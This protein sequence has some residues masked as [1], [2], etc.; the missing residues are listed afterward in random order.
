MAKR[1]LNVNNDHPYRMVAAGFP[2]M[3]FTDK[4]A[5]MEAFRRFQGPGGCVLTCCENGR[6][7]DILGYKFIKF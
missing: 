7:G 3:R 4:E 6:R 1:K 2:V 5:A